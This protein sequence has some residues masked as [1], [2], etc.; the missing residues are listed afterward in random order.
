M[1]QLDRVI[2]FSQ[3]FWLFFIFTFLYAILTHFFLPKFL[4]SLKS[5]KQIIEANNFEF[6][7]VTTNIAKKQDLLKNI[8]L[9]NLILVEN[10]IAR[11]F[12]FRTNTSKLNTQEIDE[13]I[14]TA[15]LNASLY[16]NF[17]LLNSISFYP[18]FLN[19]KFKSV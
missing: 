19:L 14:I 8:L 7:S 6:L 4:K 16:C 9:K 1:P 11:D 18:K 17:Q 12:I 2:V 5:R 10:S 3:I 15:A 13:K